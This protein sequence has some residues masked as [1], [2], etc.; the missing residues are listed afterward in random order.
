M[1]IFAAN[2]YGFTSDGKV[3]DST[4]DS[5]NAS[6]VK[7]I[8]GSRASLYHPNDSDEVFSRPFL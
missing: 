2:Q 6:A 4:V 1:G 7:R 5:V 3:K 8:L